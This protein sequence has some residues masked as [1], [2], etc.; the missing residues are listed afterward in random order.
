MFLGGTQ[1][2]FNLRLE[3]ANTTAASVMLGLKQE[4]ANTSTASVMLD[5]KQERANPTAASVMPRLKQKHESVEASSI[6][7]SELWCVI[8]ARK[9]IEYILSLFAVVY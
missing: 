4:H 5:L 2:T 6:R 3:H 8:L 9:L 7:R 1:H